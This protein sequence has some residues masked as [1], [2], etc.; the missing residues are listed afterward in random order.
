MAD[1]LHPVDIA[2]HNR[3]AK[4]VWE[5][6]H[7]GRPPRP[8]VHLGTATQFFVFNN[9]LNPS[10]EVTFES[11]ST[12]AQ[13]MLDFQLR[14]QA[15]RAEKITP[16]CDDPIGL[17]EE[18]VVKVD[19]Q[20]YDEAAYFGAPVIFL[21]H[22][23]PDVKPI[24][25]GEHKN[26][27]L[28]TGLPDPLTGGWYAKAHQIY[29]EMSEALQ[30]HPLYL[31]RPVRMDP[32]G[33]WTYGPLTLAIAL[34]GSQLLTDFYED[35]QYVH[36]LLD[37]VVEG[38]IQRIL[39]HL[40]FFGLPTPAPDMFFADDAIQMISPRMLKEFLLPAYHKLKSGITT[41]ERIKVHL[42]GDATRHFRTLRDELGVYE[43]ETGFPVDFGWL[44]QELGPEVLIH[45]G[46]SV[47]LLYEGTPDD[48][49]Q[50]TRRI[51]NSGVTD[52]GRFVLRESN[53]LAPQTPFANL[54]AMYQEARQFSWA[55]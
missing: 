40:H 8:P 13:T 1:L 32:F 6:F 4:A 54:E 41:A 10:E 5:A 52:G 12:D 42:C 18:F 23:L 25:E 29:D 44:R 17:P 9:D 34:R 27:F 37:F 48:V 45:G 35:P 19:L 50:E 21:P 7:A 16:Y 3:E 43:F 55:A 39:A 15:W 26:A 14:S 51:L 11:Y 36:T 33:I 31:E 38:T 24:L 28:D 53:N 46:P 30:K 20:N 47:I 22:Q 2:R 49:R